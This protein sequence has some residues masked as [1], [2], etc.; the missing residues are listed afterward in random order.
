MNSLLTFLKLN[1][2]WNAE[3]NAPLPEVY[4]DGNDVVL[5]FY[6]NGFQ[7]P[8][9]SE[10]E[11]GYL[12]FVN[13][14]RYRLGSTNDEGWYRGQCRFDKL[15]PEWGEFYQV[16]GDFAGVAEATDW[17]VLNVTSSK[18]LRHF[19]FYFRDDTFECVA[20]ECVVEQRVDNALLR[21]LASLPALDG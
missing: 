7:F 13:S 4:V 11:F 12:R 5:R 21:K 15:A 10:R 14:E 1:Q 17:H 6:L 16:S 9:F 2:G 20:M 3:P 8:D 19:L 18:K